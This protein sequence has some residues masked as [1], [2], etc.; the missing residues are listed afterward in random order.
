MELE[1]PDQNLGIM[2]EFGFKLKLPPVFSGKPTEQLNDWLLGFENLSSASGW[3]ETVKL[4]YFQISLG[5][6]PLK[7][8]TAFKVAHADANWETTKAEFLNVFSRLSQ[9]EVPEVALLARKFEL[10]KE[11]VQDYVYEKI[12]LCHSVDVSMGE[13]KMLKFVIQG[14][15]GYLQKSLITMSGLTM[16]TLVSTASKLI[17]LEELPMAAYGMQVPDIAAVSVTTEKTVG[18]MTTELGRESVRC[19]VCNRSNHTADRCFNV[20]GF[21]KSSKGYYRGKFHKNDRLDKTKSKNTRQNRSAEDPVPKDNRKFCAIF[22]S[23]ANHVWVGKSK[24][25]VCRQ[26]NLN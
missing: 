6:T 19:T 17:E 4:K 3:A 23:G 9:S 10:G 11:T 24:V 5:G 14:L 2:A 21:P 12:R 18:E 20:V 26:V 8:Y 1:G 13:S 22:E 7:W 16:D 25:C 15:P